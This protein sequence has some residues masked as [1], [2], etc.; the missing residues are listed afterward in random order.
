MTV[1]ATATNKGGVLKTSLTVNLAGLLAQ[2]KRKVLI[3]DSDNQG[4]VILSFGK[5]PDEYVNTIYNVLV[6]DLNPKKAIVKV[7]KNIDVLVSND[8]MA[9][10]EFNVLGKIEK[11][12]KPFSLMK[13]KLDKLRE[14]YDFVL[15]DT[16][17]NLGL[18]LGNVLSYADK[19]IIPF[20]PESYSMRSLVKII[21]AITDF[22]FE[23]NPKLEILG[24]VATLVDQRTTLHS[25]TL[26]VLRQY[27]IENH[28]KVFETVIPRSIRAA[29]AVAYEGLPIVLTK[30]NNSLI[31][32][33]LN[34]FDELM[35]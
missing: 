3:I 23:H 4:N 16:P 11:F 13:N 20:Q 33:Y 8:D 24:V 5:N 30:A 32:A 31:N 10:F 25:Q 18:T 9:F 21:K 1:I 29:S 17:P 19:V 12:P 34:L 28:I 35:L 26:Q 15:I 22:R 27:C 2:Q 6:E 7:H 14:R